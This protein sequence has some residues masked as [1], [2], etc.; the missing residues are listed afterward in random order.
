MTIQLINL[1]INLLFS[2]DKGK[3]F[4]WTNFF[5]EIFFMDE[6]EQA[7]LIIFAH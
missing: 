3:H 1:L 4:S 2:S 5:S 6:N 7:I